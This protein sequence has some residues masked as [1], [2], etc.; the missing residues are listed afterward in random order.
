[1]PTPSDKVFTTVTRWGK[2]FSPYQGLRFP[3]ASPL[4]SSSGD[5]QFI[6]AT[7]QPA[8]MD[9]LMKSVSEV[10]LTTAARADQQL[11]WE[12]LGCNVELNLLATG[13][14]FNA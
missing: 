11:K 6:S 4:G 1:M 3:P 10:S 13:G 12:Q 9:N 14:N 7:L 2:L 5:D 8:L